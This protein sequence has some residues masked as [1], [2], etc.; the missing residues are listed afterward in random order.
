MAPSNQSPHPLHGKCLHRMPYSPSTQ[1]G[2]P[3]SENVTR[4]GM[5]KNLAGLV[6]GLMTLP[7]ARTCKAVVQNGLASSPA[8]PGY[9][10]FKHKWLMALDVDRCI[11]CGLCVE[12]CC[13]ENGVPASHFR[14]WIERYV[15]TNPEGGSGQTRGE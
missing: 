7:A 5:L 10:P 9:D 3:M 1:R 2:S 14:T 13:E 12:A 11:G 8:A 4:R 6:G 15:I